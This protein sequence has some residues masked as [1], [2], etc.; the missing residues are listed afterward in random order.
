[1]PLVY[2]QRHVEAR[3]APSAQARFEC[4]VQCSRCEHMIGTRRCSR[5]VC[6]GLR[7]CWQ[8]SR[9]FLHLRV[10][11][12]NIPNAGKGLF[13]HHTSA[14]RNPVFKPGDLIV[15]YTGENIS[16]AE[17]EDRYP[18]DVTGAYALGE[19]NL[20]VD[21]AC[22]RGIGSL[23]NAGTARTSNAAYNV[24]DNRLSVVATKPIR[25]GDEILADYGVDYRHDSVSS[26]RR[27]R[28]VTASDKADAAATRAAYNARTQAN[29]RR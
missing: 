15:E 12:S 10:A 2:S 5:R 4:N 17:L 11:T 6:I 22:V 20:I 26:T 7:R 9:S 27:R 8:H 25:H 13:A 19:G 21:S 28:S 3:V 29:A 23:A 18:G 1:M 24:Y 16:A 14:G